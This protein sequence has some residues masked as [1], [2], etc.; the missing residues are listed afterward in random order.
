L[1]AAGVSEPE[2]ERIQAPCGL[3]IG[4]RTPE[5]TAISVLAEI[6]ANSTGRQ[7]EPLSE[8]SGRI[9]SPKHVP[10]G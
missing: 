6:I 10:A 9:H 8:T 5:E 3:D 2:L 7:G 4:A 1:L